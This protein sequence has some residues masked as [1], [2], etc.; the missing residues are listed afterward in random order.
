MHR[1]VKFGLILILFVAVASLGVLQAK[2]TV[3]PPK[4][5]VLFEDFSKLEAKFKSNRWSE[6]LNATDE[7][8]KTFGKLLPELKKTVNLNV[9]KDFDAR[10]TELRSAIK[11]KDAKATETAYIEMHRLV[12]ALMDNFIYPVPPVLTIVDKY[13]GE[14]AEAEQLNDYARVASEMEEIDDFFF[15]A[16]PELM[17]KHAR[18]IDTEEFKSAARDVRAAGIAHD[19][20]KIRAGIATMK[21]LSAGF[22]TLYQPAPSQTNASAK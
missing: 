12:F 21:R 19:K 5:I 6:A 13:I 15:Q 18:A 16:G 10:L 20:E 1:C 3:P 14:A 8:K 22:I 17:E 4:L 9:E 11:R 7:L 2:A